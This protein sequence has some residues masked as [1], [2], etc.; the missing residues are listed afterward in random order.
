MAT[1]QDFQYDVFLSHSAKDKAVVRPLAE[2]LRQDGLKVWFDEW[3]L[4]PEGPL[5]HRMGEG[6]GVRAAKIEAGLELSTEVPLAHRMGEGARRAGEGW[7][8]HAFG[9]D[10]GQLEAG[11]FRFRDPLNQERR[12]I[13]L[14]LDDAPIKGGACQGTTASVAALGSAQT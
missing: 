10:W 3:V 7:P 4:K 6:A 11:T 12:F 1:D 5:A 2:R 13:P 8:A 9:S 14:R